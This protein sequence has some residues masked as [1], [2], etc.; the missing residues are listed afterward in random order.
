MRLKTLRIVR[1]GLVRD[2]LLS[3]TPQGIFIL[4]G[5][6]GQGKSTIINALMML[7]FD[8][9]EFN[10]EDYLNWEDPSGFVLEADFEHRGRDFKAVMTYDGK[11]TLRSLWVSG[12]DQSPYSNSAATK[13]LAEFLDPKIDKAAMLSAQNTADL[14]SVAPAE[15]REHL[16]RM[17]DVG[18]SVEVN[19]LKEES[20]IIEAQVTKLSNEILVLESQTFEPEELPELPITHN[21]AEDNQTILKVVKDELVEVSGSLSSIEA[22]AKQL[23]TK[24][25]DLERIVEANIATQA[26]LKTYRDTLSSLQGATIETDSSYISITAEIANGKQ[27]LANNVTKLGNTQTALAG[28]VL[29]RIASF[30]QTALIES[31]TRVNEFTTRRQL[32]QKELDGLG[33]GRC[34]ACGTLLNPEEFTTHLASIKSEISSLDASL[35]DWRAGLAKEEAGYTAYQKLVADNAKALEDRN[36]LQRDLD[37][38]QA[39]SARLSTLIGTLE[40]DLAQVGQKIADSIARLEELIGITEANLTSSNTSK[41][42]LETLVAFLA[43][44][45][46]RVPELTQKKVLLE[47]QV[48]VLEGELDAYRVALD[49]IARVQQ[50]NLETEA[51]RVDRDN[52][53]AGLVVDRQLRSEE[54]ADI[55][56]AR[57]IFEKD[58]PL[59]IVMQRLAEIEGHANR[60]LDDAYS[61]RYS[62]AFID[63]RNALLAV[64]GPKKKDVRQASGYEKQVFSVAYKIAL[65]RMQQLGILILDESDS[66]ASEAN[67]KLF[68]QVVGESSKYV[69]QLILVS[70]KSGTKELLTLEYQ[71]QVWEIENG[72]VVA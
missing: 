5:D 13:R 23:P 51:K 54:K 7:L 18:F 30:D 69:P 40:K 21:R 15:R 43:T 72:E 36:R 64:Y 25:A 22:Q 70:H 58:L 24:Q 34:S 20:A 31:R 35:V 66:N 59:W 60:F 67:S 29:T 37:A 9:Y 33:D 62:L 50:R 45:A 68:Y 8:S 3:F 42:T 16:R 63:K 71:A 61:G 56:T 57:A 27:A 26:T 49:R 12:D 11:S 48:R 6:N 46:E 38:Q 2:L 19:S 65:E 1:F 55:D 28:I 14:V 17:F 32:K 39:E 10:L 52:K 53:L 41:A 4:S 44:R 47:S